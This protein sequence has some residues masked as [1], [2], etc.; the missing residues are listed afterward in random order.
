MDQINQ[1]SA[2]HGG[3]ILKLVIL[4]GIMGCILS[5]IA[6]YSPPVHSASGIVGAIIALVMGVFYG[7]EAEKY[8]VAAGGAAIVGAGSA[9]IGILLGW[10]LQDQP[11]QVLAFGTMGGLVAGALGGLSAHA[12]K[13]RKAN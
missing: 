5:L 12:M 6:K 1:T 10:L 13:R 4:G 8:G 7:K 9:F 2:L 3:R 11:G